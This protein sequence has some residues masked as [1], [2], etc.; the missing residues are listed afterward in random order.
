YACNVG[1]TGADFWNFAVS[2]EFPNGP[3]RVGVPP[4]LGVRLNE[5]KDGTSNTLMIGE[6]HVQDGQFGQGNNDC[7]IYDGSNFLCSSRSAGI[8]YPLAQ[9]IND[10][11]C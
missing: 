6:K 8:N 5:I 2:F 9:S 7:C 4:G 3:F 11:P 10:P 1:T